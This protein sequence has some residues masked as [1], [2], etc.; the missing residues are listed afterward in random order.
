MPS[1]HSGYAGEQVSSSGNLRI[2]MRDARTSCA[3]KP[4]PALTVF[5]SEGFS[6]RLARFEGMGAKK[7]L[8]P[9]EGMRAF[10]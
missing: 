6:S 3:F 5:A 9:F 1:F 10:I 4:G 2:W 7:A 8:D